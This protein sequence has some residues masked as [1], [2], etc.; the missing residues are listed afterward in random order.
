MDY[1]IAITSSTDIG[2]H[3]K[4]KKIEPYGISFEIKGAKQAEQSK[5]SVRIW[6]QQSGKK[7][8]GKL[9]LDIH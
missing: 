2:A 6:S 7:W 1:W 9:R 5:S 4:E 8:Q 3:A